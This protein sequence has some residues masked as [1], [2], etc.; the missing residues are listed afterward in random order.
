M[1][2]L[3]TGATGFVGGHLVPELVDAGHDVRALV[4]DPDRYDAPEGVDVVTGDLLDAESL[5]GVFDGV[6]AAYYLVHSMGASGDFAERDRRAAQQFSA[7]ADAAGVS[8]V[9]YLG[10][11]GETGDD[12]SPHLASR[13]EVEAVLADAAFD[14]TT[15]RA[16]V[17]VGAGSA[18][19]DVVYQLIDALPVM[20]TP[21]WV[22]T[23]CQ[24]IAVRDVVAYLVG[25]LDHP[26]TAGETYEVGGPQVLSYETMLERT[27]ELAG[28]RLV[29]LPVPVLSPRLSTYWVDLVTDVPR[30]VAHPLIHGLKN[31]VVVTDPSIRDVLPIELTPFADAARRALREYGEAVDG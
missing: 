16:A 18:G 28:K 11:L 8:R 29:V 7:A 25:V 24:P 1:R 6:D 22:R 13:R 20:V 19:F 30:S 17:I 5:S 23:P 10:G 3:V 12:L 27:A 21:K 14:L 26:E 15:L 31:P 2:V 4:R 9:V